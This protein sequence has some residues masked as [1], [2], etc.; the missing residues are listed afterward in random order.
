M[1]EGMNARRS[2]TDRMVN[3]HTDTAHILSP[4]LTDGGV[5]LALEGARRLNEMHSSP[6]PEFGTEGPDEVFAGVPRVCVIDDAI[7]FVGRGRNVIHGY[8][9]G[10]DPHLIPGQPCLVVD[11]RGRLVAHGTPLATPFEMAF[12]RKGIAVKVRDGAMR[13]AK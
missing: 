8:V 4:R 12:L 11:S 6:P 10:A 3:V 2:R 13:D 1:T 5:S 7:P 9:S